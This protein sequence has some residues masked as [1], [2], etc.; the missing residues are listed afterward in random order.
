[1]WNEINKTQLW[2]LIAACANIAL[3]LGLI[4]NISGLFF[5]PIIDDLHLSMGQV[6][7]TVAIFNMCLALGGLIFPKIMPHIR[8][9]K[10]VLISLVIVIV[11]SFGIAFCHSIWTLYLLNA[12]RGIFAGFFGPV[13][14]TIVVNQ[15]FRKKT[16]FFSG[17]VFGF[18]GI[19]GAIFAPITTYF[20][21]A[22]SW[23]GGYVFVAVA[24]VV[25][26]LPNLFAKLAYTPEE[27]NE[28][29]Y[30]ENSEADASLE[31]SKPIDPTM[32]RTLFL[33]PI[34]VGFTVSFVQ[35][36]QGLSNSYHMMA[37]VGAMML[38]VVLIMN[39]VG[40][41]GL[42]ILV[43][44]FGARKTISYAAFVVFLS[45]LIFISVRTPFGL[46][47]GS[48]LFGLIYG[49]SNIGLV[50][51]TKELFGLENYSK[52]YPKL[53][54][55]NTMLNAVGSSLIGYM[56]DWFHSYNVSLVV[57][58]CCMLACILVIQYEY[59]K[60]KPIVK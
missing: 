33:F 60:L 32:Y 5:Q 14:S 21:Q 48:L 41:F 25:F 3:A 43:D 29:S 53:S 18:A 31:P 34:V 40:K 50:T 46:Y 10:L 56:Y 27:V 49:I 11:C 13:A 36:F 45:A 6:S 26:A 12:I 17:M 1:M 39:T 30:G 22:Y 47:I 28:I 38:S 16:G 59:Q 51:I 7:T 44:R 24:C 2:V 42:G 20:I 54:V 55:T 57:I 52:A 37:E 15:W 58:A 9:K 35:H 8:Y 4:I 19:V 23:R